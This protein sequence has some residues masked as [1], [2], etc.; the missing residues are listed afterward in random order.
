MDVLASLR[1]CR[2]QPCRLHHDLRAHRRP[3]DLRRVLAPEYTKTLSVD[4]DAVVRMLH[5]IGQIAQNRI[6]FQQISQRLGIGDVVDRHELDVT[7]GERGAH[8][9]AS[10]TPEAVDAYFDGHSSSAKQI[11][12]PIANA[13]LG[14]ILKASPRSTRSIAL[15]CSQ[16]ETEMLR[17][18][19]A[20]VKP[21]RK[22]FANS[23]L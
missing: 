8:D 22:A 16:S 13:N 18:V 5:G 23:Y 17:C 3:I 10:D 14:A 2:E 11:A 21:E 20:D 7:V 4:G 19:R 9:V 6:V 1:P 15:L 12:M